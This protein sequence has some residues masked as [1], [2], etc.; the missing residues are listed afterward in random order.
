[1]SIVGNFEEAEALNI[2]NNVQAIFK[3]T[4]NLSK[5]VLRVEGEYNPMYVTMHINKFICDM[6][7]TLLD[8]SDEQFNHRA[9]LL[10]KQYQGGFKNIDE[11]AERYIQEVRSGAYDFTRYDKMAELLQSI[12]KEELLVFWN[13]YI[14]PSTA[15]AYTRIDVQMWS[16]K[17]WGPTVSDFKEYSAKTLALYGCLHSEGNVDFDMGKVD[18]FLATAIAAR[19]E[20]PDIGSDA[21]ALIAELKSATLSESGAVYAEG[22]NKERA[23]HTNTAL[24]LIVKDH[25]TFGNYTNVSR[26]N[27]ATIGM[28]KTPDG[29]WIMADYKKLQATQ[30]MY[31]SD[32]PVEVFVPKYGR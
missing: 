24:E 29:L 7:Q 4:S 10:I 20:Q 18:A 6:Q 12:E 8:I 26:T 17:I 2:A 1:M 30:E 19:Q 15:P 27:F 14:S 5:L 21:D 11:E 22:K 23:T 13:K 32:L 28:D 16:A 25:E 9:Q 31:G 3:P